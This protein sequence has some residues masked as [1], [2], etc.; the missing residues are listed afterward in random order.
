MMNLFLNYLIFT[1]YT[2]VIHCQAEEQLNTP[3]LPKETLSLFDGKT[4]DG[5]KTVHPKYSKYW[6]VKDGKIIGSNDGKKVPANTYLVAPGVYENFEL[7]FEFRLSGDHSK[8]LINSGVQ[9][10]SILKNNKKRRTTIS[11]YQADIGKDWWGG[12]YDEH[13]RGKLMKGDTK[14]LFASEGWAHDN[15]QRYRIIAQGNNLQ[16]FINGYLTANYTEKDPTIPS[17]GVIAFQLH[18]GGDAKI[19]LRKIS[20][21]NL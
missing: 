7:T 15:W 2:V 8:G 5:W 13:R 3:P 14:E 16:L 19:E 6:S 4:L 20:I 12:I 18:K 11:G 10:R 21:K 17:K 1:A 9:I